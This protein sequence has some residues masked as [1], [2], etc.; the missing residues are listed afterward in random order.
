V[1]DR[2]EQPTAGGNDPAIT[3]TRARQ[4]ARQDELSDRGHD[5]Q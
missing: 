4:I 5:D 2:V 3:S 1:R